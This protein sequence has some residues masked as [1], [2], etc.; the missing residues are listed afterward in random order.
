MIWRNNFK[1]G[2][3]PV[4]QNNLY[5]F[6]RLLDKFSRKLVPLWGTMWWGLSVVMKSLALHSLHHRQT[7]WI[8]EVVE[9]SGRPTEGHYWSFLHSFGALHCSD[10]HCPFVGKSVGQI[11]CYRHYSVVIWFSLFH[12]VGLHNVICG[13]VGWCLLWGRSISRHSF[14]LLDGWVSEWVGGWVSEWVSEWVSGWV[15]E[16][17]DEWVDEWVGEWGSGWV[18]EWVSEWVGGRVCVG[19]HVCACVRLWMLILDW[20][21][22]FVLE[23]VMVSFWNLRGRNWLFGC[24]Q[25]RKV[26]DVVACPVRM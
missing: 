14:P 9:Q 3:S 20:E 8:R 24:R 1:L 19:V 7:T 13:S 17:V 12:S 18:G 10:C 5:N 2:E 6:V 26:Q 21:M 4:L 15:S 23:I 25:M 16:W 11:V 22:K